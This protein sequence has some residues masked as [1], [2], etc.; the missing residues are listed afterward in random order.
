VTSPAVGIDVS[1]R[2]SGQSEAIRREDGRDAMREWRWRSYAD[3]LQDMGYDLDGGESASDP[4][5]LPREAA[6]GKDPGS[7]VAR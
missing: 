7:R 1:P 5:V 3:H 6:E 4:P 2:W